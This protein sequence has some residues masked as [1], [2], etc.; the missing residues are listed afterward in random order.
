MQVVKII[1]AIYIRVSTTEQAEEGYSLGE[2]EA[3]LRAYC[4]AKGWIV[5]KVYIDGGFSGGN[6]ERPALSNLIRDAKLNKF[7]TVL[8][9]KLDRLSRS[10]KDTL[11]LIEDVFLKNKV[12]FVSMSENFDTSTPFGKAMIGILSVFAQLEREQIKERMGLGRSARAK[13]G[14]FHGGGHTPI[15]YDYVDGELIINEYEAMQVRECYDLF[16][17]GYP[18]S[19]IRKI[20]HDKGYKYKE[21]DW[22]S[23]S[24]VTSCLT[25]PLYYGMISYK[26]NLYEGRHEPIVDKETF[27][28]VQARFDELDVHNPYKRGSRKTPFKPTQLLSGLIWCGNCGAR[29]YTQHCNAR[30]SR[31]E[32]DGFKGWDYYVCYSRS[33]SNKRMIKDP[34]CKNKRWRVEFAN[35]LVIDEILKLQFDENYINEIIGNNSDD[36]NTNDIKIIETRLSAIKNQIDKVMDLYQLDS[37]PLDTV[38]SRLSN[39]NSERN[40]LE[41]ELSNL[42]ENNNVSNSTVKATRKLLKNAKSILESDDMDKKRMLVHSLIDRI[43]LYDDTI[44][45]YWSFCSN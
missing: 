28:K 38:A 33:K 20:L 32:K 31:K 43:E 34:N 29:Y 24:T 27:D 30:K 42:R 19:R 23:D 26:G 40:S 12:D 9:Y 22:Y 10:Q 25:T 5:Y 39:L 15:G 21:G 45:I 13:D 14:Y 6:I 7:D 37:I 8:V 18:I 1:V 36:D 11:Y 2:Q 41:Y 3:R 17:K 44:K 35:K 16:L 4:E